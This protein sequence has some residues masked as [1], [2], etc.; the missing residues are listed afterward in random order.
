MRGFPTCVVGLCWAALPAT[1]EA[2][3]F[4]D[5]FDSYAGFSFSAGQGGWETWDLDPAWDTYVTNAESFS[6]PNSLFVGD[7]ADVV[8]QFT[9]VNSGVWYAKAQTYV[10]STQT[11]EMFFILLNTYAPGGTNNWS[12]QVVLCQ[13][14]CVTTGAMAGQ[15][16]NLGGTDVPGGGSAPLIVDQWVELL[17][18]IDFNQSLYWVYYNGVL[19]DGPLDWTTTGLFELQCMDLFSNGSSESYMD[20]IWLDT[21]NPFFYDGFESGDTGNWTTTVP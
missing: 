16:V 4:A 21:S 13:S 5:S 7:A 18:E 1:V 6:S 10:P 14:G 19:V 8:Q 2:Q 20:N 11:G 9:G 3:F 17:V 12:V 15:V